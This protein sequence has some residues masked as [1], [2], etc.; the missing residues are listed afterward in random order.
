[1]HTLIICQMELTQMLI[2]ILWVVSAPLKVTKTHT[3]VQANIIVAICF[4]FTKTWALAL[5]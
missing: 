5:Q 3:G 2:T 1:M 4:R